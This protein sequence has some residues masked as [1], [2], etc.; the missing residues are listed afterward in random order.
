[1]RAHV[2][3]FGKLPTSSVLF[4]SFVRTSEGQLCFSRKHTRTWR[5]D[6]NIWTLRTITRC[7]DLQHLTSTAREENEKKKHLSRCRFFLLFRMMARTWNIDFGFS[8]SNKTNTTYNRK[9][10]VLSQYSNVKDHT[11]SCSLISGA[12]FAVPFACNCA[13]STSSQYGP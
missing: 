6:I 5:T 12:R 9:C 11:Q 3:C 10:K 7:H 1:M 4:G 8:L 2:E 13:R